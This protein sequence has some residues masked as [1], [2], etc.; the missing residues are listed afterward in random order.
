MFIEEKMKKISE[1]NKQNIIFIVEGK[2]DKKV[3]EILGFKK[4]IDI[5]GKSLHLLIGMIHSH[6]SKSV[7][8]LTDFDEDGELKYSRLTKLLE[9]EG[10]NIDHFIRKKFRSVFSI[11]KI[12]ELT[13][14]TKFM[15]DDYH[16]KT[17]SIYDKI[18]NR[19]RVYN[20]RNSGET[21][22]YR[23]DIRSNG[24]VVGARS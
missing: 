20:R 13:H 23:G 15:E 17:C 9:K 19:S 21:R 24:G 3:L 2:K 12:E 6:D 14:F 4:I 16:G 22:R 5:S 18:F 7:A 11:H 10:I 1:L 8:I